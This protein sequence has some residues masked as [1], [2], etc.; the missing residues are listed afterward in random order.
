MAG[1]EGAGRVRDRAAAEGNGGQRVAGDEE[2]DDDDDDNSEALTKALEDLAASS[3]FPLRPFLPPPPTGFRLDGD[4]DFLDLDARS[5]SG[6]V[7]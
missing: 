2:E 3:Y 4:D 7:E 1:R 6:E 5:G